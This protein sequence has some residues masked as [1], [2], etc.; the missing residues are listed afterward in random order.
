MIAAGPSLGESLMRKI[1]LTAGTLIYGRHCAP[2]E[3][4]ETDDSLARSLVLRGRATPVS[5]NEAA[6]P[7]RDVKEKS[8]RSIGLST[9]SA[10]GIVKR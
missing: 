7:N 1:R 9:Q 3:V 8:D 5:D 4:I 2:G 10:S 6:G